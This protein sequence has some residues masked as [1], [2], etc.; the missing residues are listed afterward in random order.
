MIRSVTPDTPA[1][2]AGMQPG[3]VV[4]EVNHTKIGSG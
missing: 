4:L 1:A 2:D 3:D